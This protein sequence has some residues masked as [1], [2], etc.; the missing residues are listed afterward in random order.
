VGIGRRVAELWGFCGARR[1]PDWPGA[2]TRCASRRTSR[3]YAVDPREV[4]LGQFDEYREVP[5]VD[6]HSGRDTFVAARLWID[7]PRW[8]H[9]PSYLR[10][11][12]RL[13]A[14]K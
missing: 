2:D 14:S 11:R 4:V 1:S 12:K 8:R 13:A 7:N 6:P 3:H 9:V 10:T 5:G